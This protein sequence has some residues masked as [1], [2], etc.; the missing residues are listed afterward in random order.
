MGVLFANCRTPRDFEEE[1]RKVIELFATQAAAAIQNARLLSDLRRQARGHRTLS[2]VGAML[3]GPLEEDRILSPVA[4]AAAG[5]LDCA[6]CTVSRVEGDYLVVR[7]AE[8]NRGWSL[9]LGRKFSLDQIIDPIEVGETQ[10]L[11]VTVRDNGQVAHV[12]LTVAGDG[13]PVTQHGDQFDH[14]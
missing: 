14:W 4:R 7:P 6:H 9:S 2:R 13:Q 3:S 8:G 1:E 5:T 11:A 10:T 12:S